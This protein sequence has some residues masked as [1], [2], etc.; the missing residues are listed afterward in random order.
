LERRAD[1]LLPPFVEVVYLDTDCRPVTDPDLLAILGEPYRSYEKRGSDY[2]LANERLEVLESIIPSS[3]WA[4]LCTQAR[5]AS[6]LEVLGRGSPPLR[7]RC[8]S[9]ARRAEQVLGARLAQLR[10]RGLTEGGGAT[11][12]NS[13]I[14]ASEEGIG[15]ALVAGI[16]TP[17]LR[18]DSVGFLVVSGRPPL[19]GEHEDDQ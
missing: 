2:N 5:E 3:R 19:A 11:A 17:L 4:D 18:L 9:F 14:L 13:H 15:S 16:R 6:A 12:A 8:E 7:D 1:E 10:L